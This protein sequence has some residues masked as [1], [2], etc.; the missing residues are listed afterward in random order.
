MSLVPRRVIPHIIL[1][2]ILHK[3]QL[4]V[5][6]FVFLEIEKDKC[7]Q[8]ACLCKSHSAFSGGPETD[9]TNTDHGGTQTA[10]QQT[11]K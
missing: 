5:P 11:T 10:H 6:Q 9:E 4:I 3:L 1:Q 2:E 8:R 7:W